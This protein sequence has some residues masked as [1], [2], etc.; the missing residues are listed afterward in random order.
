MTTD[1][2]AVLRPETEI[3]KTNFG[4]V[5]LLGTLGSGIPAVMQFSP[6]DTLLAV[7]TSAGDIYLYDA[8]NLE[9]IQTIPTD[10][11]LQ[12]PLY[13][14][15]SSTICGPCGRLAI[16]PDNKFLGILT[17]DGKI[18]IW[19]LASGQPIASS[20]ERFIAEVA[21]QRLAG[22]GIRF[23]EWRYLQFS[24]NSNSLAIFAETPWWPPNFDREKYFVLSMSGEVW[25]SEFVCPTSSSNVVHED[26]SDAS[27]A[28]TFA[29]EISNLPIV[30]LPKEVNGKKHHKGKSYLDPQY[31]SVDGSRSLAY[32]LYGD[33]GKFPRYGYPENLYAGTLW[34]IANNKVINEFSFPYTDVYSFS[35]NLG[36][37]A[38]MTPTGIGVL[39]IASG[40]S[41]GETSLASCPG[42]LTFSPDGSILAGY[43]RHA[44]YFCDPLTGNVTRTIDV[45]TGFISSIAFSP[46][47]KFITSTGQ[48][49]GNYLSTSKKNY[50]P[51]VYVWSVSDGK[52]VAALEHEGD[53]IIVKFSPDGKYIATGAGVD[54]AC[55]GVTSPQDERFILWSWDGRNATKLKE[56]EFNTGIANL[57]FSPDS[58]QILLA[59][60]EAY[61][62]TRKQPRIFF[63]DIAKD[64]LSKTYYEM[65]RTDPPAQL[66]F[67][68]HGNLFLVSAGWEAARVSISANTVDPTFSSTD[69]YVSYPHQEY[70]GVYP[71]PNWTVL[72]SPKSNGIS[73]KIS[74]INYDKQ[75]DVRGNFIYTNLIFSPDGKLIY[76]SSN[77]AGVISVWGISVPE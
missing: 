37:I 45:P 71:S 25:C 41:R 29:P 64:A 69:Y 40:T 36:A 61:A 70:V 77:L 4:R 62:C 43:Y 9:L 15:S 31:V 65:K 22:E 35:H 74:D 12:F 26:L 33:S 46:D 57:A 75:V 21:R 3:D 73:I 50:D 11:L 20:T 49:W 30:P 55:A 24:D 59:T 18:Q 44:V 60:N 47:G 10:L 6:D 7:G 2:G 72:V 28:F 38:Y 52:L 56:Q 8:Q 23:S 51:F 48:T 67:F 53:T 42:N 76:G 68:P 58:Q 54:G 34:D 16:S 63:Y 39:D 17:V 32:D 1:H 19:S 13:Y 14:M 66:Q 27:A 5:K